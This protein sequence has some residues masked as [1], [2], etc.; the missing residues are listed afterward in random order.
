LPCSWGLFTTKE[1]LTKTLSKVTE[2]LTHIYGKSAANIILT[3]EKLKT[4]ALRL[5][6]KT[7]VC[8]LAISVQHC[9]GDSA[10]GN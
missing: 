6:N 5:R 9:D 4:L 2:P 8:I 7:R 10:A 3:G 1:T